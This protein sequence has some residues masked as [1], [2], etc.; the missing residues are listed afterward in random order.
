M[1][2]VIYTRASKDGLRE[3]RSVGEQEEPCRRVVEREGWDLADVFVDND[4]SASRFARKKRDGFADL[5]ALL[6]TGTVGV[7]V[8]WE[9]SRGSR[10]NSEWAAML[11]TCYERHVLVHVVDQG[12]T[13][14]PRK[15]RDMRSLQEDGVDS[16][17][18]TAK[19][20]SRVLRSKAASAVAG[21][22]AGKL[23]YGYARRYNERGAFVE[24]YE[25]PEQSAIVREMARRV[26]AGETCYVVA[27]DLNDRGVSSPGKARWTPEQV[28]RVL[29]NPTYAGRRVHN[30]QV[31][32]E[33]LWKPIIEPADL[34]RLRAM[35]L[36]PK[37]RTV[38][39]P[40]VKHLLSGA[41]RCGV[42][43][44]RMR[45][46]K[47]RGFFAYLCVGEEYR[48]G[49]EG[50]QPRRF[51]TS[52]KVEWLEDFVEAVVIERLRRPDAAGL[53]V[54]PDSDVAAAEAELKDLERELDKAVD[55]VA[56]RK[57]SSTLLA[58]LEA[59]LAPLIED[60]K[61]RSTP[62]NVPPAALE[63]TRPGADV[64]KVWSRLTV[65]Q[66]REVIGLLMVVHVKKTNRGARTFQRERVRIEWR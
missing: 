18:E 40:S 30:G 63:L 27:R 32:G 22:P 65:A 23:I 11:E 54:Q 50:E 25:V 2:A 35:L 45:V 44:S 33:G 20:R 36:D 12:R 28:K 51:C 49:V 66:R 17:Y 60:A 53:F 4:L 9:S 19:T 39:D 41:A 56:A 6:G 1:R 7:L 16:E 26:L 21:R 31:V 62:T 15:P 57:M 38:R 3:G 42:C 5:V 8:L 59:R 58:K 37:R 29:V 34:D 48:G 64:P 24:Q 13:L 43:G 46:Q 14:D 47:N 10:K 52:I 61:R 55:Q